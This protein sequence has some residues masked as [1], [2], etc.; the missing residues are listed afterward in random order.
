MSV[1]LSCSCDNV[2]DV[3]MLAQFPTLQSIQFLLVPTLEKH[4]VDFGGQ[5]N[6]AKTSGN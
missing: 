6:L 1:C 5:L 4:P 2:H 3:A